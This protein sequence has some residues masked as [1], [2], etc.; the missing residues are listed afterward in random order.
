VEKGDDGGQKIIGRFMNEQEQ[1][2]GKLTCTACEVHG[3][4]A[5]DELPATEV[6]IEMPEEP[7]KAETNRSIERGIS[8]G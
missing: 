3:L 8:G 4:E 6:H 1:Q 2:R 7:A 5:L